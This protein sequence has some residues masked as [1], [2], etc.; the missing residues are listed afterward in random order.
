MIDDGGQWRQPLIALALDAWRFSHVFKNVLSKLG[1][2]ERNRYQGRS[3]WFR[4]R[5]DEGLEAVGMRL[6]ELAPGTVYD[7]GMAVTPLNI[8]DFQGDEPLYVEQMV[9]P[10]LMENGSIIKTGT[11]ILGRTEQ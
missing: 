9:E 4:R 5:L 6:V 3:S 11:V 7:P 1:E 8:D 10:I 2:E